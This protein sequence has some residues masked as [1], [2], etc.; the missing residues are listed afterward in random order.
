MCVA[1]DCSTVGSCAGRDR[2][3]CKAEDSA[4]TGSANTGHHVE[5]D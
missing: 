5:A 2:E 4:A 1:L 3:D